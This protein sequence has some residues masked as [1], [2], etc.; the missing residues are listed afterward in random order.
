MDE[1]T[2]IP[3]NARLRRGDGGGCLIPGS[4][5]LQPLEQALTRDHQENRGAISMVLPRSLPVEFAPFYAE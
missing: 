4:Y 1:C 2:I 3:S 5:E